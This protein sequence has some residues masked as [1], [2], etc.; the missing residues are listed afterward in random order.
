MNVGINFGKEVRH[1]KQLNCGEV[2]IP[3]CSKSVHHYGRAPALLLYPLQWVFCEN[4]A[5]CHFW[6]ENWSKYFTPSMKGIC[7][8]CFHNQCWNCL[9]GHTK[10]LNI[11]SLRKKI[12]W[13]SFTT[14]KAI[15]AE[16]TNWPTRKL[17][18]WDFIRASCQTD[19][20]P[21]LR[22]SSLNNL[23][24]LYDYKQSVHSL[25]YVSQCK[26]RWEES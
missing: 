15:T 25:L 9:T 4:T 26:V 23:M 17:Y 3:Q 1:S 8:T 13:I 16:K 10:F 14:G 5:T 11:T 6:K 22:N 12:K 2:A 18:F 7:F 19:T 21:I 20:F 24:R